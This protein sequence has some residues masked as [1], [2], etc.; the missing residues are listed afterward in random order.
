MPSAGRVAARDPPVERS[1]RL[2]PDLL[3]TEALRCQ[4]RAPRQLFSPRGIC[5]ERA[6]SSRHLVEV[7]DLRL[8]T[9][10]DIPPADPHRRRDER[11]PGGEVLDRLEAGPAAGL[12]G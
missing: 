4:T 6:R 11:D 2:R 3:P 12:Q 8:V 10:I 7:T 9:R 1:R 5:G